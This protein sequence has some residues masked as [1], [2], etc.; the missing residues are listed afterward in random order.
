MWFV[1]IVVRETLSTEPLKV[2]HVFVLIRAY[3]Q[4]V[5]CMYNVY[6]CVCV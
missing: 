6:I 1:C 5:M 4:Y 3:V 2:L